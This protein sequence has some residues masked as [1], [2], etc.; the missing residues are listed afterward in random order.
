MVAAEH[1]LIVATGLGILRDGGNAVDAAVGAALVAGV[2]LPQMCGLGGDLFG[3]VSDPSR[4]PAPT[5]VLGSG[6][7]PRGASI[8]TMRRHGEG[9]GRRMPYRGPL[10]PSVPGFVDGLCSMLERWGSRPFAALAEPAIGYAEDGAAVMSRE[11][12][13]FAEN[14]ALLAQAPSTAAVFLAGGRPPSAG[15]VL[16]QPDLARSLRRIADGGRDVFYRGAIA[17]EIGRFLAEAGGALGVAEFADHE[18]AIEAPLSTTYRG[19]T[20]YQTGL[21]SQGMILLEALNI[22]EGFPPSSLKPGEP[23]TVHVLAE[24]LKLAYADRLGHAGDPAFGETP[25]ATLLSK[26]WAAKRR[27][28]IDPNRAATA[29]P[30]G[31]LDPG[32]TTYLCVADGRGA[33]VSLIVSIS[34]AFGSGLVAGETG[35]VLNN[36]AGR[37]FSLEDGHPNI[38]AP[39]KKTMHTLNCY[40]VADAQER[41][42]LV[43]G[44]FGGDGQPQ[45]NLQVLTAMID[46]GLDVQAAIEAPR[47]TVWPGTDP[48]SLPNPY[49]LRVEERLGETAIADLERRGHMIRR[50][51]P[52]TG[53]G[54]PQAIA[55]DPESGVLC[56][57]SDPRGEGLAL[58]W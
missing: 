29:V 35:I 27:G 12:K 20:V 51:G 50:Q 18:T 9:G 6:I 13:H 16:R 33:L 34:S 19:R 48:S 14:A 56:G 8:E 1:P 25:L 37:G 17:E 30:A 28:T 52:W 43:G 31:R 24:A 21:P 45:W 53:G 22:V 46:A 11:A 57:G 4:S 15:E 44:S 32:E 49:E 38:Y 58:G 41:P 55:R 42:V 7:A 5:A 54:A 2:V 39:G 40:L 3:I 10:S 26:E 47:W 36:R 23:G